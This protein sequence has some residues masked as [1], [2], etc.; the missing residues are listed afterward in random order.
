M[1]LKWN[2]AGR[3]FVGQSK[4]PPPEHLD[5]VRAKRH[6]YILLIVQSCILVALFVSGLTYLQSGQNVLGETMKSSVIIIVVSLLIG[7]AL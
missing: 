3:T 1:K 4:D 7:M 2:L 5:F 6:E